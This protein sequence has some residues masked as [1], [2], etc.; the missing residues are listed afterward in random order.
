MITDTTVLPPAETTS[1]LDGWTVALLL[2]GFLS[3]I[4]CVIAGLRGQGPARPTLGVTLLLQA[5]GTV[6]VGS[7]LVRSLGGE[8][9]VGPAWELWAYLVTVLMVPA[10]AWLWARADPTRWGSF[11]LALAGFVVAVMGARSAQIW[12][13]VGYL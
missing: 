12:H 13:G 9:P 3:L 11:V 1:Y 2:A 5:V 6:V 4:V 7:Y 10:V 8:S